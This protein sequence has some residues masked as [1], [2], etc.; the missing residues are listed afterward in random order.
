MKFN[1]KFIILFLAM[2]SCA[3]Q[4]HALK[5]KDSTS[6]LFLRASFKSSDV[7]LVDENNDSLSQ[8]Y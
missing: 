2:A 7:I 1:L 5:F 6:A 8:S 4:S 3:K